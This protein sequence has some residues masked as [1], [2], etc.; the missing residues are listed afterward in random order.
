MKRAVVTNQLLN[1][2]QAESGT[3][4]PMI[5][6]LSVTEL[7]ELG[8]DNLWCDSLCT[9]ICACLSPQVL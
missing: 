3:K 2:A 7:S 6:K 8:K 4:W 9:C 1:V 5:T